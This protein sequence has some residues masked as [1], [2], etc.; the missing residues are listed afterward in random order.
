MNTTVLIKTYFDLPF[1]KKEIL[2]Y[3]N[4]KDLTPEL[5]KLLNECIEE[6]KNNISYKVCYCILPISI[7]DNTIDFSAFKVNSEKLAI[8]LNNCENTIVFG[9][10]LGTEIDR[11]IMKYGKL[12]PT[13]ALFFQAIGATQIETLCDCFIEDIKN[14]LNVNLKPRFSAGFGDLD[15]TCQ[16]DIF[17]ILDCSKKIGLT[18][19]D[20]LLMSPTKSVTAFVGVN[21]I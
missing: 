7:K 4:C 12:S 15:L 10:T 16:K 1:N 11:L 18:L 8:N 14:E 6:V 5:E 21:K 20:S 19:N 13:K 9:A 3:S 17:K 2:R